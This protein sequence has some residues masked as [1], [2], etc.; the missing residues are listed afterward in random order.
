MDNGELIQL[1]GRE[2]LLTGR[3]LIKGQSYRLPVCRSS[4]G[5]RSWTAFSNIDSNEGY[6]GSLKQR[7]L[8]EP[9]FSL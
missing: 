8:W 4:D 2:I 1:P 3:S 7:G 5:G 6:P 9:H